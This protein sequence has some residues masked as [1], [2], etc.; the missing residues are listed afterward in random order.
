MLDVFKS[1]LFA[2]ILILTPLLI[3]ASNV[4]AQSVSPPA[5]GDAIW[6]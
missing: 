6:P 4:A 2:F 3:G 1:V 5:D